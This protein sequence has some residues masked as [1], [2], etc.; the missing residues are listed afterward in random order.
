MEHRALGSAQ[1][2][3]L[4][5]GTYKLLGKDCR[6]AVA[7]ALGCGYRH[8]DTAQFYG[9]ERD[10]GTGIAASG[11]PRDEIFLTTKVWY[12][13]LE[14]QR[15]RLR[16]EESLRLLES[17]YIDL[18]LVHWPNPAVPIVATLSAMMELQRAGKIRHLGLSNFPVSLLHKATVDTPILTNQVE[19]HPYL[20]QTAVRTACQQAGILLTAFSPLARGRVTNDI[21]LLE[22]GRLHRK[23]PA[24][25]A[26]RWLLDQPMVAAIPKATSIPHLEANI[27]IF[28]FRLTADQRSEIDALARN[29]RLANPNWAPEWD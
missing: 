24:Q 7:G 13:D 11:V 26:L 21:T 6:N 29:L 3:A 4:G 14:P 19:Y 15:L 25:V 9:N 8:I 28:D 16:T 18:L 17:D 10:V 22:I 20:A 1:M 27:D 2:P 5:L 23:S 12:T